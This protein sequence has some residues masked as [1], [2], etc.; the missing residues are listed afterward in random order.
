[1]RLV[2][3]AVLLALVVASGCEKSIDERLKSDD[4]REKRWAVF[5]IGQRGIRGKAP[6]VMKL[7]ES[8]DQDEQLRWECISTLSALRYEEALPL[9]IKMAKSDD[10]NLRAYS[11]EALG[12]FGDNQE[13][14]DVLIRA[15]G[16]DAP[17]VRKKAVEGIIIIGD[18]SM[19]VDLEE[20]RTTEEDNTVISTIEKGLTALE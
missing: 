17:F 19:R 18:K 15:L 11:V 6:E 10:T 13:A 2:F 5:E 1:M 20:V 3:I 8:P 12:Y 9:L 7:L 16:D 4:V 14:R